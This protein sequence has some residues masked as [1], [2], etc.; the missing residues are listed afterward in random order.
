MNEDLESLVEPQPEDTMDNHAEQ[1]SAMTRLQKE[2]SERVKN[3]E[4]LQTSIADRL[5]ALEGTV[6]GT[7]E[8]MHGNFAEAGYASVISSGS[9]AMDNFTINEHDS[10]GNTFIRPSAG[11][12]FTFALNGEEHSFEVD[13]VYPQGEKIVV[14]GRI[15]VESEDGD[16]I[17]VDVEETA[18]PGHDHEEMM[19]KSGS[20]VI[21]TPW[22][23]KEENST[24]IAIEDGEQGLYHVADPNANHHGA[25]KGYVDEQVRTHSHTTIFANGTDSNPSLSTGQ[26]YLNTSQK[27]IY[28]GM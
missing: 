5:S 23:L 20:Q 3:G 1:H 26:P 11:E 14:Q 25:N 9:N 17:S 19:T 22:K 6:T 16:I 12:T 10:L 27:V 8:Y 21:E 7:G 13:G 18:G 2:I 28:V 15:D 24:Y 4:V